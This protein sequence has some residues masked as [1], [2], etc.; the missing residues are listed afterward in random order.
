MLLNEAGNDF[1]AEKIAAGNLTPVFF[2]SAL[3]AFGVQTFLE[4]YLKFAPPPMARNSSIGEIDPLGDQFSGFIFKIQANMNPAHRDRIAFL[5]VCSGKFE[6]G[7]TVNIPRLGKQLKLSQSTSFMAEERNTVDEAVSGD[8]IGLYDTGTYQIG[9]TLTSG[10]DD[11]QYER[12]P[13]FTPELYIRVSAKNVMKQKSFYKGIQQL[14]QE[15]AIQLYKTIKT[16]DYLLGA[17]GQL[18][19]EVFEH[20]MRNEY[21]AEVLMERMGSKIAR[22]VDGEIVDENLSSSRSLLV[23]DRYD[24]YVFLFENDF[25]LRWFQ[26]KNPAVKLYNPMDQEN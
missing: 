25:A 23:K 4:S 17:V 11:F 1:S 2:G 21:N 16:D 6:R 14:V 26:E 12:L 20:R 3:T 7:M 13:Q 18:Q 9:D 8:I 19:F 5:R 24:H 22:W 10:K 15:G